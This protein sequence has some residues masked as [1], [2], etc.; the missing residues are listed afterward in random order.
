MFIK[1]DEGENTFNDNNICLVCYDELKE[2]DLSILKCG[3][4]FHYECIHMTYKNMKSRCCPYCRSDGGYLKLYPGVVPEYNIHYEY[5][6]FKKKEYQ[7]ELIEGRCKHILIKG[8]NKGKQCSFKDKGEG[9]CGRH[10]K[11]LNS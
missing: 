6:T 1:S 11:L 2:E 8:K 7:I 5:I 3:H 9:Y 4:K 10:I